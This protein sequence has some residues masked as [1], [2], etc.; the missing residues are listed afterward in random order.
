VFIDPQLGR[1]G[2]TE[3]EARRLGKRIRVAKMPFSSI[4]RALE[5]DETRG[6]MKIIVDAETEQILGAAVLGIEGGEIMSM[7]EIAMMGGLK[8]AALQNATLA[9][10]TLAEALNNVFSNF[11]DEA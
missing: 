4:A 10:P 6:F 9:H 3:D 2:M 11:E 1:V 5:T 7:I 8:Y